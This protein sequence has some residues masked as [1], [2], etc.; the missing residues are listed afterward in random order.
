MRKD[1]SIRRDHDGQ[2]IRVTVEYAVGVAW[3][4]KPVFEG[5]AGAFELPPNTEPP[6]NDIQIGGQMLRRE[7]ERQ[8]AAYQQYENRRRQH[9]DSWEK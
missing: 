4:D 9:R 1:V 5:D 3:D 6:L 2:W 7:L 8:D